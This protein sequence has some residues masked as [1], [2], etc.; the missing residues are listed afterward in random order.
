MF[1]P[2]TTPFFPLKLNPNRNCWL[3]RN[4][5]TSNEYK[6]NQAAYWLLKLCNGYYTWAEIVA[7]LA[8]AYKASNAEIVEYSEPLLHTMTEDGVIWWRRQRMQLWRLPPP[9]TVLWDLT[10]KCNLYCRHCVV[11]ASHSNQNELSLDKCHSLTEELAAFGVQQLILSGGEPLMRR[12]FFQIAEHVAR[13]GLSLQVATNATLITKKAAQRLAAIGAD[14]QVSL[15][16]A[17]TAVHDDCR[18]QIGAWKSAVKGIRHLVKAKVQVIVAATI[19]KVNID[20]I[21]ALYNLAADL[22]A[23][24]FRILPFVPFGR[25]G[26]HRNLEVSPQ[27]MQKTTAY[28]R[29]RRN[30]D[31]LPV[32]PMEFECTFADSPPKTVD[33]QPHI[34]CDGAVTFCTIAFNGDV[35]PCNFFAGVETGNVK[36]H[37]FAWIW[38]NSRFLN[39]FRSLTVSDI[40]G[41]C[42][43]CV[44]LPACRGSCIAASFAHKKIFKGNPHCWMAHSVAVSGH[45][46]N[47][48][49]CN[50]IS[51]SIP[52]A[53]LL[54]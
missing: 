22:G 27:E 51:D 35:L 54:K 2:D 23:N 36:E 33:H 11:S 34:G 26:A 25:G 47:R 6:L 31:R 10:A 1:D 7:E 32:A 18:Q 14:A 53:L 49:G 16:G 38:E 50:K 15:D 30:E 37:S 40:G 43:S 5:I 19:T 13:L 39:Y 44:W 20:Q 9:S 52:R 8:R 28:L 46:R 42:Q 29:K 24:T 45:S 48:A 41:A 21:P 12:D 3:I 17:T 4:P